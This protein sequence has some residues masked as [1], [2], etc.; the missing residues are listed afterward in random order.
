MYPES[1]V[2]CQY[3]WVQ[4][5][6]FTLA[7]HNVRLIKA[8][9]RFCGECLGKIQ[10][11]L[12]TG[13]ERVEWKMGRIIHLVFTG[14]YSFLPKQHVLSPSSSPPFPHCTGICLDLASQSPD[15]SAITGCSGQNT[16][17]RSQTTGTNDSTTKYPSSTPKC[18]YV[19][20]NPM[21][22]LC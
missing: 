11:F 14:K 12:W 20:R 7:L 13:A 9:F 8:S 22:P 21:Q 10:V 4:L 3:C 16:A 17:R 15:I 19:V 18:R 5:W 6:L 2:C 1:S